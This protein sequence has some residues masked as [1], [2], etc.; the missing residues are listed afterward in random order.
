[1]PAG[2]EHFCAFLPRLVSMHITDTLSFY[3]VIVSF[4]LQYAAISEKEALIEMVLLK[5][6]PTKTVFNV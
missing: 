5:E 6:K 1:M 3:N 4:R 2:A